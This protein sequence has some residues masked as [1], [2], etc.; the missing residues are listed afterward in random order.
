MSPLASA[1]PVAWLVSLALLLPAVAQGGA[2]T[3]GTALPV[4]EGNGVLRQQF[5]HREAGGNGRDLE[6]SGA[7]TLLGYGASR[8][9]TLFGALPY[10]DKRLT[11]DG[12][13]RGSD[14]LG[15]LRLWARYT[16]YR[17]DA[18][19][20]TLRIAPY[21]G[22]E[23][24]TGRDDD[25]DALG[26]LPRPLQP[27]SGAWDPFAGLVVTYQTLD[28]ELDAQVA[29]QANT[30]AD[31]FAFGDMAR[32]DGAAQYR[33]WPRALT[34]GVPGFLYGVLEANLIHR[35][36]DEL[37]GKAT[38]DSGGTRLF[39]SPGLQYVTRRWVIEGIV[40][41]PIVQ[42]LDGSAPEDDAILRAGVRVNF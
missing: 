38:P 26:Q 15:D 42:D 9:L 8:D 7:V 2:Q 35:D 41:L 10:L 27:G 5:L 37:Q 3:F 32:L 14:G 18:P 6:V 1:Q 39:L 25:R 31:G 17:H 23:T 33:L 12:I 36:P 28:L 22:L 30:E 4:A 24:P 13:Q 29:Y 34:G 20:R 21:L 19:G 40:Q 16:L 11:A